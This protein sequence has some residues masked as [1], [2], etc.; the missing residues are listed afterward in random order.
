MAGDRV[1]PVA[2]GGAGAPHAQ[3]SSARAEGGRINQAGETRLA[4][5]ES[6]RGMAAIAVVWTHAW[7]LSRAFAEHTYAQRLTDG[8]IY[9]IYLFFVMSGYLLFW[10]FAQA[11]WGNRKPVSVRSYAINRAWRVLPAYYVAVAVLI[12]VQQHGGPL[13]FWVAF[14]TFTQDFSIHT[15][16]QLD[17]PMWSLATEMQFYIL[18]P[19]IAWGLARV[20]RGSIRVAAISLGII[21]G[22]SFVVREVLQW[23]VFGP[24]QP[25]SLVVGINFSVLELFCYFALGMGLALW[26]ISILARRPKWLDGPLGHSASWFAAALVL[27]L[28]ACYRY[29]WELLGALASAL[30]IG[31]LVLPLRHGREIAPFRWRWIAL[32]GVISY[33]VYLWHVPVL[34]A[35]ANRSL[36]TT[37]LILGRG[38]TQLFGIGLPVSVAIG[39]LSYWQIERRGLS[40]RRRWS[41]NTLASAAPTPGS[42]RPGEL[43]MESARTPIPPPAEVPMESAR[44]PIP[45]PSPTHG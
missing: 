11:A 5:L 40:R 7:V 20:A 23:G 43:P 30:I 34:I 8:T 29:Q 16:G 21:A 10:P 39:A 1:R 14:G 17:S 6:V 44:T 19:L 12:L 9:A 15:R 3:S 45:P 13:S 36:T 42:S 37:H 33:S 26:R 4:G 18:L 25:T 31:A 28:L 27:W 24:V 41:G 2:S 35:I 22:G 38:M 32:L